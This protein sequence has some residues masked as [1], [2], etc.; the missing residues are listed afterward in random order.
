VDIIQLCDHI[1][2]ATATATEQL[3]EDHHPQAVLQAL[4]QTLGDL[5]E[6]AR[7]TGRRSTNMTAIATG[8]G[9]VAI[10]AGGDI[11]GSFYR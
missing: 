4:M 7:R 10:Q 5:T 9:S 1:D 2:T 3:A 8:P 11:H 6:A